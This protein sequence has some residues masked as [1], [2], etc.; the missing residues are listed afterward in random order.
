MV[1]P[2]SIFAMLL[3]LLSLNC[4]KLNFQNTTHVATNYMNVLPSARFGKAPHD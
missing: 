4:Q 2:K 3:D 1:P